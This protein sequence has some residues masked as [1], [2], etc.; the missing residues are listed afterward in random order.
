MRTDLLSRRHAR[1]EVRPTV[2]GY[3]T[4]RS[5]SC[6]LG[7]V[8]GLPSRRASRTDVVVPGLTPQ[9]LERAQRY[10]RWRATTRPVRLVVTASLVSAL[11][12]LA[13]TSLAA[14][15]P[16]P[17]AA[18][19]AGVVVGAGVL[20]LLRLLGPR[21]GAPERHALRCAV[22]IRR[23]RTVDGSSAGVP[24]L[25]A[26]SAVERAADALAETDRALARELLWSALDAV[27]RQDHDGA[28]H[29]TTAMLRLAV[30]AAQSARPGVAEEPLA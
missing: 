4:S 14:G 10:V 2:W 6:L 23:S 17:L 19:V 26:M 16:L 1:A 22:E 7:Q 13:G 25:V 12:S 28:R 9:E 20:S 15:R 18:L 27:R 29:A 11:A 21:P 8:P 30:Q 5:T 24:V 3:A